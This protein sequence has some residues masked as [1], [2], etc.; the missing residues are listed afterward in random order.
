MTRKMIFFINPVSGTRNKR[1]LERA[2]YR[3]C[4]K[5]NVAFEILYTSADGNYDFLRKR[6]TENEVTD[7]IICGG[8][9]SLRPIIANIL[10]LDV[11]I[12][13]I[14]AGSGNGLARTAGIPMNISG[15][16]K[17][18]FEGKA[19][20]VDA[21]SINNEL[22]CHLNGVGFDARVAHGF[23]GSK[24]RGIQ[25]YALKIIQSLG[26]IKN[27]PFTIHS[28]GETFHEQ[29][30]CIAIA[31]SNQFG[32]NLKVAPKASICDQ[33]LDIVVFRKAGKPSAIID[34]LMQLLNGKV[35]N[36][37]SEKLNEKGV[38]YFQSGQITI[39]NPEL[40]P[41]HIDG[42]PMESSDT[43]HIEVLPNAYKL[44]QP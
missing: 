38:L 6:I 11:N 29:A 34:I 10:N 5:R 14:P 26:A 7:I 22:S 43:I 41:M 17:V 35:R 27:Y 44:L 24:K 32:N 36:I 13:I 1:N 37:T 28:N 20:P 4:V 3:V 2:I 33:L 40:A 31:N 16:L 19:S 21:I 42:D 25:T 9:G 18:I 30:F 12:G 15:A 39:E 8:D 23:A